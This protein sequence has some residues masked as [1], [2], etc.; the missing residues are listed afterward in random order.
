M[1]ESVTEFMQSVVKINQSYPNKKNCIIK[2]SNSMVIYPL[3][4]QLL[5]SAE[6]IS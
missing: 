6:D 1:Q 2:L 5:Y 3:L 4:S